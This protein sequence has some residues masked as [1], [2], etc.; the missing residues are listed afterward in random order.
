[1][2]QLAAFVQFVGGNVAVMPVAS[3]MSDAIT[4]GLREDLFPEGWEN[5]VDYVDAFLAND[6]LKLEC[7]IR[8]YILR[9]PPYDMVPLDRLDPILK[10]IGTDIAIDYFSGRKPEYYHHDPLK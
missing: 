5:E 6:E 1:M 3:I 10:R 8:M 9:E 7:N 2:L 4:E